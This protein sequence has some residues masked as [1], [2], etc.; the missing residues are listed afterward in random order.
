[1][2]NRENK[3]ELKDKCE[4]MD[5]IGDAQQFVCQ[6]AEAIME[7]YSFSW[8][9]NEDLMCLRDDID[10]LVK[11]NNALEKCKS[12]EAIRKELEKHYSK[13]EVKKVMV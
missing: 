3:Y 6:H 13:K 7:R 1:M 4:L 9:D 2:K 8:G 5:M 12:V 10:S 11:I